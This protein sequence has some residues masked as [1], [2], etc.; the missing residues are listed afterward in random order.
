[1]WDQLTQKLV[2]ERLP[3]SAMYGQEI[4]RPLSIYSDV[5]ISLQM[6]W[7]LPSRR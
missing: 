3:M 6:A 1:M 4:L 7:H 2:S 5:A